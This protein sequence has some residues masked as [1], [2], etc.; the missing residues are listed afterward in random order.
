VRVE[1]IP[2]AC[3]AAA[4][5]PLGELVAEPAPTPGDVTVSD[6]SD[7]SAGPWCYIVHIQLVDRDYEPALVQV[8]VPAPA[9]VTP[10]PATP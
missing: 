10:P 8:D 5:D 4:T 1:R 2:G 6:S 7:L 3:P 9:P